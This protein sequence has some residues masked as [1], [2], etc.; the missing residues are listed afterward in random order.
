MTEKLSSNPDTQRQMQ[1]VEEN[2]LRIRETIRKAAEASGRKEE[3]I[4]LL[5]ATQNRA[6]RGD[7]SCS[8]VRGHIHWGK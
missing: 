1:A 3:D 2:L 5:A 4:R 6:G 8:V 7:Q